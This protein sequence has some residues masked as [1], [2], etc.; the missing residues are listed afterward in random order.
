MPHAT[1]PLQAQSAYKLTPNNPTTTA[2]LRTLLFT[3]LSYLNCYIFLWTSLAFLVVTIGEI[4][5]FC[6]RF[7][8]AIGFWAGLVAWRGCKWWLTRRTVNRIRAEIEEL[9]RVVGEA[10]RRVDEAEQPLGEANRA[11]QEQERTDGE[12]VA[13]LEG[14]RRRSF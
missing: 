2:R 12:I 11:V 9:T 3:S 13:A 7:P 10:Q 1:A 4:I 6:H 14:R 8:A 5:A